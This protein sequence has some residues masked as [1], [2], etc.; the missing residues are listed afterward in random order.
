LLDLPDQ[1]A[2]RFARSLRAAEPNSKTAGNGSCVGTVGH[3]AAKGAEAVAP[4][5]RHTGYAGYHA[6]NLGRD[7]CRDDGQP[8]PTRAAARQLSVIDATAKSIRAERWGQY[9]VPKGG[10]GSIGLAVAAGR[11]LTGS[12]KVGLI[13]FAP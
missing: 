4:P 2:D 3:Q 13:E 10:A 6:G 8:V 12:V 11:P 9:P 1:A 5:N 7:I